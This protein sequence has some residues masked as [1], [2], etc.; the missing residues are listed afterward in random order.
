MV[1]CGGERRRETAGKQ[2]ALQQQGSQGHGGWLGDERAQ[3]GCQR[4]DDNQH[5]AAARQRC[6]A[7]QALQY[8]LR[9]LQDRA[10]GR[11]HHDDEHEDR[12]GEV[13]GIDVL[14][15]HTGAID[16]KHQHDQQH[17]PEAKHHL[18]LAQPMPQ[19]GMRRIAV[20]QALEVADAKG[21][22]NGQRKQCGSKGLGQA[23][24][25]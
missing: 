19:P 16:G 10:C 24:L 5:A 4:Q 14:Q 22:Q 6:N 25:G 1:C 15:R 23:K 8:H 18:D 3:Q 9:R 21:V 2:F 12:F 11:D 13:A 20:R 17:G 7:G